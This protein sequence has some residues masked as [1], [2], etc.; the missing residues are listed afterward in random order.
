MATTSALMMGASMVGQGVSS[1]FTSSAQSSAIEAQGEYQKQMFQMNSRLA[2]MQ[3]DDA[4]RRGDRAAY[5]YKK[6]VKRTIGNQRAALAAQ[7]IEVNDGS[8]LEVQ[9]DTASQGEIDALTI[10]NNAYREA[11]GYKMEALTASSRGEY[12]SI[13]SKFDSSMTMLGGI[14]GAAG[15]FLKAGSS[16]ADMYPGKKNT[17][18]I[19]L[20]SQIKNYKLPF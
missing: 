12:A 19:P 10:K 13:S 6:D 16:F 1:L 3:A 9:M 4:I 18:D 5:L 8:A 20:S 14:S 7:G 15:S 11:W 2:E 17:S